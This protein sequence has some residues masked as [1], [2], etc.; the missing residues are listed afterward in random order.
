MTS[1]N[2]AP[3]WFDGHFMP[4]SQANIGVLTH[5]LHYGSSVFEGVRFYNKKIFKAREH[6]ERLLISADI[7]GLNLAYTADSIVEIM[8]SLVTRTGLTNGYIRPI[9][10]SGDESLGIYA[11]GNTTHLAIAAWN[12][13]SVFN[14]DVIENGLQM[15]TSPYRRPP[16]NAAPYKAKAAGVYLNGVLSRTLA[17]KQ[18]ADD[19]LVLDLH[20]DIAEATG[21]NIFFCKENELITPIADCFLS[22][23]TRE[24]VIEIAKSNNCIVSERKV[25]YQ[26][27]N[28]FD[29]CFLTGTAYEVQPVRRIDNVIFP[30]VD[31]VKK[32]Q[33]QYLRIVGAR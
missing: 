25:A 12:W 1:K 3:I 11:P 4:T 27:I 20:G 17:A 19:A 32:L 23:I 14:R 7:V 5:A 22:G 29:G 18:G 30:G 8:E 24:V 28:D 13:P 31:L 15:V 2:D 10:W 26:E 33:E 21:A 6:S 9:A 16:A